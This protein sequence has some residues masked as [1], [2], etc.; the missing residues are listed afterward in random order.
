MLKIMLVA[1]EVSGDRQAA[2]LSRAIRVRNKD[3]LLF[4]A[5]GEE[6]HAAGVDIRVSTSHLGVVGVSE[7]FRFLK[8]LYGVYKAL[9]K[10]V[11]SERPDAVVLIDNEG[12]NTVFARSLRS[13]GIPVIFYFAPQVWLWGPWRARGIA[14]TAS[15]ILA[16]F[17]DE[18]EAYERA[19]AR[20]AWIGHPLLDIVKTTGGGDSAF[21]RAGLDPSRPTVALMPGSRFHEL[22]RLTPVMAAAA[23]RLKERRPELQFVLPLSGS[24]YGGR[25]PRQRPDL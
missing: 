8:P 15:L 23:R 19:G 24:L 20:V 4:G 13:E 6:M 3:A 1:G 22:Q 21:R 16:V 7:S 25:L 11:R 5:G 10:L 18:A 9:G 17:P 12:F 14:K 2:F